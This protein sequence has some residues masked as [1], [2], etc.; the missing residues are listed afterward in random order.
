M[1]LH[2]VAARTVLGVL[3]LLV[4]AV[5]AF[6]QA[7]GGFITTSTS[8]EVRPTLSASQIQSFVPQ[9]GGF[10]FPAPYLTQGA[11][12]TNASDCAGSD[13]VWYVGYSYWRNMNNHVGSDT[14]LIFLGLDRTHGGGGPTLFG[15]SKSSRQVTNLGP[16]FASSN[17]PSWESAEGWYWSHSRPNVLYVKQST[18]THLLRYDVSTR[19]LETVFDVTPQYGTDKYLWQMSSS[20]DDRV[21]AGTLRQFGSWDMLGCVAYRE[22]TRQFCRSGSVT[23]R[24]WRPTT[25]RPAWS[26][27]TRLSRQGAPLDDSRTLIEYFM[28][29]GR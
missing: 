1:S 9:R 24:A 8:P 23:G 7:Q 16:L 21:H 3:A 20:D 27:V 22:D 19:E 10:T 4:T 2:H 13:C 6:A 26:W 5:P 28:I 12:I 18:G 14:I 17:A 15:Y 29:R 25:T 11:R